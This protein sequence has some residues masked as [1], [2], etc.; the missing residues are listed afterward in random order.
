MMYQP[1]L[2]GFSDLGF[3]LSTQG[4][5]RGLDIGLSINMADVALSNVQWSTS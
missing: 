3:P 5:K 2:L 1:P 4:L